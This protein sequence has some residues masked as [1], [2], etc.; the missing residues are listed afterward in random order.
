MVVRKRDLVFLHY[1]PRCLPLVQISRC[2][3]SHF[4]CFNLVP[5]RSTRIYSM[6]CPLRQLFPKTFLGQSSSIMITSTHINMAYGNC[7]V[8]TQTAACRSLSKSCSGLGVKFRPVVSCASPLCFGLLSS[9]QTPENKGQTS[10]GYPLNRL[11]E[12]VL[13]LSETMK[14]GRETCS[15]L[16]PNATRATNRV[17][18]RF[19]MK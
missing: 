2:N 13:L 15:H 7:L 10:A 12:T 16:F 17:D 19:E 18:M 4:V 8:C 11:T 5:T 1:P 3:S 14:T 9:V 6:F